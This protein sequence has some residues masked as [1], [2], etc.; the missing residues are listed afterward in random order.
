MS[1]LPFR[2]VRN[3]NAAPATLVLFR[4][5]LPLSPIDRF[6]HN[7]ERDR[8]KEDGDQRRGSRASHDGGTHDLSRYR[9]CAV[10]KGKREYT[11]EECK[12]CHK[13]W[14]EPQSGS[15]NRGLSKRPSPFMSR[16]CELDDQDR[17]LCGKTD[18]HD[19]TDLGVHVVVH[20]AAYL[21]AQGYAGKSP[22]D[23]NGRSKEHTER[24]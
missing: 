13:D 1:L 8:N 17:V 3:S 11:Q 10:G 22:E 14:P 7:V 21:V 15:L 6:P 9:A 12:G 5:A 18:E 2:A 24:E 23:S 20:R 4:P 16:L 19:E